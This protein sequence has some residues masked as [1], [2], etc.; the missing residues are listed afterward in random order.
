M[1]A[2]FLRNA[3]DEVMSMDILVVHIK[4]G[5]AGV[6]DSNDVIFLQTEGEYTVLHTRADEYRPAVALRDFAEIL[7][8]EGFEPL[9]KSNLVNLDKIKTYDKLTKEIF[10]DK[11]RESKSVKVSRRN[12]EKLKGEI[13]FA[14]RER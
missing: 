7:V 13:P 4:S 9:S 12:I 6:I 8:M 2:L 14:D 1:I 10:F 5:I 11:S 3:K